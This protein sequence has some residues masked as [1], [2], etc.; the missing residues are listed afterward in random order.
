MSGAEHSTAAPVPDYIA[1][2]ESDARE[3]AYDRFVRDNLK[4]N[5]IAHFTHGMLGMTGFRLIYTPTFVPACLHLLTGS[6][7]LVG[8]GQALH[9]AGAV[10]SPVIGATHIEHRRTV[11]PVAVTIGTLMRVQMLGL[12]LA[13]WFL[14]G[15]GRP[16]IQGTR[17]TSSNFHECDLTE[18]ASNPL[19]TRSNLLWWLLR[20]T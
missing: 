18:L 10:L 4:R 14:G 17:A 9:Q 11:L 8:L 5:Y 20:I 1:G 6:P 15:I 13:G 2:T 19:K 3:A 16:H 12:A 7:L